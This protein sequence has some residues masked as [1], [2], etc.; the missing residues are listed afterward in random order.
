MLDCG[1]SAGTAVLTAVVW[2]KAGIGTD[3]WAQHSAELC[4]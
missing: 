3:G 2:L 4:T 1:V